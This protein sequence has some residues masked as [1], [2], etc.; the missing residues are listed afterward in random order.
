M[1][2]GPRTHSGA[3]LE[4]K[5]LQ[6]PA[7]FGE[8]ERVAQLVGLYVEPKQRRQGHARWLMCETCVEAD[9]TRTV[10]VLQPEPD[11]DGPL[12]ACGLEIFYRRFG[13]EKIQSEPVV[14]MARR[15]R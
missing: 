9:L 6:L 11:G 1:Q 3:R 8:P 10:L 4:I 13:F 15:P 12:D 7:D 14:L 5:P 2:P